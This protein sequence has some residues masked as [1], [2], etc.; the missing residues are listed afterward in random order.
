MATRNTIDARNAHDVGVAFAR[1]GFAYD[2]LVAYM[3]IDPSIAHIACTDG[4]RELA[5]MAWQLSRASDYPEYETELSSR[6]ARDV[7]RFARAFRAYVATPISERVPVAA[8]QVTMQ[9]EDDGDGESG[10]HLSVTIT[11]E[12]RNGE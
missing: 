9:F 6:C 11:E 8:T 3:Q 12:Y 10:P 1:L 7:V 5:R 2:D 4:S